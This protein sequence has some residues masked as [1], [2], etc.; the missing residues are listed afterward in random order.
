MALLMVLDKSPSVPYAGRMVDHW[1]GGGQLL[2]YSCS[3]FLLSFKYPYP[4]IDPCTTL[5]SFTVNSLDSGE[6]NKTK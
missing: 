5:I 1:G 2:K 4:I 6:N 3:A